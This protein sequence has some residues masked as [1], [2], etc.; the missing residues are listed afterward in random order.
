MKDRKNET[1][2][3]GLPE[4][5]RKNIRC[6]VVRGG[7]DLASGVIHRLYRCGYRVLILE[8]RRPSS[9]RRMVSFSEAVYDGEAFVEGVLARRISSI[10]ECSQAWEAGEIPLLADPEALCMREWKPEGVIDAI[11]AK[12]NLGTDKAM[13]PLTIA[14]GP[15]FE[16]GDDVDY[17]VETMRGHNLGRII[18]EG[19]ALPNTGIPGVVAGVSRERVIHSP[20]EGIIAVKAE[21]ADLVEQGQILAYVGETPVKATISGVLRGIIRDGYEVW[22]GMKIADIDP[23][24]EEKQNCYT[25]SDK[26]RCIAG[27]VV[28]ILLSEGVRPHE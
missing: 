9:I 11:L 28:E 25:I 5:S 24:K 20:A 6:I 10:E 27:S 17:V 21:I 14:L 19:T 1:V 26:A 12:R 15:G 8:S 22:K 7:G 23:R 16:A 18:T 13:A 3:A 4:L 2:Q